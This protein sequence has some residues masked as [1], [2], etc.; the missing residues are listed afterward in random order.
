MSP[1]RSS[2]GAPRPSKLTYNDLNGAEVFAIL[3]EQFQHLMRSHPLMQP[4]LTLPNVKI[5]LDVHV[6]IDMLT[7]GTVPVASRPEHESIDGRI[8]F[9]HELTAALADLA[10]ETALRLAAERA[11]DELERQRI[12]ESVVNAAPEP[13]GKPPDQIRMQHG[14]PVPRPGYGP[15]DT[16]SHM[17]LADTASSQPAPPRQLTDPP[18]EPKLDPAGGRRG[19]VAQGYTFASEVVNVSP[20]EQRMPA[21][22][23]EIAIEF[24]GKGIRH[25]SG[26]TVKAATH[27][28]SVKAAGDE[29]GAS[30]GGVNG[31]YDPGPRGLMNP[32]RGGGGYGTDGRPRLSFGNDHR[33][34]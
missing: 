2:S 30:Y 23:G 8:V 24:E 34:R 10:D 17:F 6:S 28:A 22:N 13:G 27:K 18:L 7:G 11:A 31:V 5:T 20:V 4:H 26:M 14:L 15:R 9:E 3:T 33:G 1:Q 32:S 16:G 21:D 12:Y 29:K 19:E 25:E